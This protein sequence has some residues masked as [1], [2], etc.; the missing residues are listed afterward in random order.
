[1][2]PNTKNKRRQAPKREEKEGKT[3]RFSYVET[4]EAI[5]EFFSL[6]VWKRMTPSY[7]QDH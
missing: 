3:Q 7:G 4:L 6:Q 5:P 2:T 1:M